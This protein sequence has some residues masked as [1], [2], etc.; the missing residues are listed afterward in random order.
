MYEGT[1]VHRKEDGR[2][3]LFRPEQNAIRM[4]FGA[5]RMSMPS[6]SIDQFVDAVKQTVLANKRWVILFYLEENAEPLILY[7]IIIS[8]NL[9]YLFNIIYMWMIMMIR[10]LL[11]EKGLCT[12]GLCS[13]EVVK[14]WVW[15]QHLN[16]LS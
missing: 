13:W 1:K 8:L 6:P 10:F 3:L 14:Y 9:Y 11:Q 4:K 2:L 7:E 5:E 12:L 16:T 15:V